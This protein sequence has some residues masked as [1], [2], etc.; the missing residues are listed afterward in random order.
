VTRYVARHG[1]GRVAKAILISAIPPLFMKTAKNPDGAPKEGVDGLREG[2]A[3]DR[4]Q[5]YRDITIP[6]YGFNRQGAIVSEGI[7]ENW[8]RQGMMGSI[9]LNMTVSSSSLKPSSMTISR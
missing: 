8:W 6:F 2:T 7:R 9:R 3:K 4:S 1:K 5:F